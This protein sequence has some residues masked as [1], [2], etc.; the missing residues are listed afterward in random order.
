MTTTSDSIGNSDRFLTYDELRRRFDALPG[1]PTSMGR[2]ILLVRRRERGRREAPERVRLTPEAGVSGDAWRERGQP[3]P[4]AQIA[5]MQADVARL[6]ANGQPLELFGDNLFLELDLTAANL[7]V[8]SRLRIGGAIV[9]VTPKAHN[10]C[11]KFQARFGAEALR[12]VVEASL[13]PRNLRGIYMRVLE[14]G[15]VSVGDPVDVLSR[16]AE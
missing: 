6:I 11:R 2:V 13:R 16:P 1:A 4:A 10:G 15:V 8:G 14:P 5:V 9:E 3:D 7:P 12:F